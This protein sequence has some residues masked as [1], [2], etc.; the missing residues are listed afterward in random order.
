[1]SS[2]PSTPPPGTRH[3]WLLVAALA[4]LV[5]AL[6]AAYLKTRTGAAGADAVLYG[7]AVFG[8]SLTLCVV[9]LSATDKL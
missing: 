6:V 1:M 8:A 2:A 3:L 7:G 4:S 9:V 5:V